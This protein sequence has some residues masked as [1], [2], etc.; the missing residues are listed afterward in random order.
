[1]GAGSPTCIHSIKSHFGIVCIHSWKN[2]RAAAQV[3]QS[4][5]K[6]NQH[7]QV[8]LAMSYGKLSGKGSEN[9]KY[10]HH[11][12]LLNPLDYWSESTCCRIIGKKK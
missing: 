3:S 7:D 1:M 2:L 5:Y 8:F 10:I 9:P 4:E 12:K 6:K 11:V